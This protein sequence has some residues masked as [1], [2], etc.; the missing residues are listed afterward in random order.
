MPSTTDILYRLDSCTL[1]S[2]IDLT[3][4]FYRIPLSEESRKYTA[5]NILKGHWKFKRLI[6]KMKQSHLLLLIRQINVHRFIRIHWIKM[7]SISRRYYSL[8]EKF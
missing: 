3:Q 4:G 8:W 2:V 1:F 6:I 5:F 7:L